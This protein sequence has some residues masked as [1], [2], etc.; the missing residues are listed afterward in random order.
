MF[1]HFAHE[2]LVRLVGY[3]TMLRFGVGNIAGKSK[4][5]GTLDWRMRLHIACDAAQG[6]WKFY[7]S[8]GPLFFLYNSSRKVE[9]F[10]TILKAMFTQCWRPFAFFL[11]ELLL[12]NE[13]KLGNETISQTNYPKMIKMIVNKGISILSNSSHLESVHWVQPLPLK[14]TSL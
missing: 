8:C 2:Y 5:I 13:R 12:S 10:H 11:V 14:A 4:K 9:T 1:P 3:H 6:K 7:L